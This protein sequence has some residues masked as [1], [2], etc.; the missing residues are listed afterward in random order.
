M[1]FLA[2]LFGKKKSQSPQKTEPSIKKADLESLSVEALLAVIQ[3][4]DEQL[5]LVAIQKL[6]DIDSLVKFAGFGTASVATSV[7]KAAKQRLAQLVDEDSVS[8]E[9]LQTLITDKQALMTFI[10]STKKTEWIDDL[11]NHV[12]D[13][14][15]LA[16]MAMEAAT[17][18]LRQRAAE[19]VTDK[20]LLLQIQKESKTKDKMV[21]KIV[22]DK[23]DAFKE[24]DKFLQDILESS[25]QLVQTIQQ[26]AGRSYDGQYSAKYAYLKQQWAAQTEKLNHPDFQAAYATEASQMA[27]SAASALQTMQSLLDNLSAEQAQQEA[28]RQ[29]LEK[30][31]AER[32]NLIE[33]LRTAVSNFA[34]GNGDLP[35]AAEYSLQWSQLASLKKP[36]SHES[37]SWI[38]LTEALHHFATTIDSQGHLSAHFDR[39]KQI[40]IETAD[41]FDKA[42][43]AFQS[44]VKQFQKNLNLVDK[45]TTFAVLEEATAFVAEIHK[46]RD[47]QQAEIQSL[48]RQIGGLIRKANE[49]ISAGALAKASGIRRSIDEKLQKLAQCPNHIANQLEQLDSTLLK[50]QDWKNYAVSP[51]K[52]EL[53]ASMQ[54]LVGA[55]DHPESLANKI[56]RLQD[57]WRALS[58]GTKDDDQERWDKF[59]E[60]AQQAYQP[61]R[62]FFDEQARI[63]QQ[64]LDSCKQLVAQLTDYLANYSWGV[65]NWKDV[66]KVVRVARQEWRSYSPTERAATQPVLA[67]FERILE[68]INGKLHAEYQKNNQAKRALIEAAKQ[69]AQGDDARKAAEGI[70]QLQA[71]WQTIGAALRKDEQH[72][73]SEFRDACDAVF[74]KRQQQSSEFKAELDANLQEAQT[75]VDEL[76]S[77]ATLTGEALF[78]ARKRVD[79]IRDAFSSLGQFPKAS[80]NDIKAAFTKAQNAYESAVKQAR[81]Q[82]KAQVWVNLFAINRD[83]NAAAFGV[84]QGESVDKDALLQQIESVQQWPTGGL[85]AAQQK[86]DSL[87]ASTDTA[88][89]EA[90]LRLLCVRAELLVDAETPAEDQALRREYQVSQLQQNFGKKSDA[91]QSALEQLIFEWIA[92]GGVEPSVYERLE[93]RFALARQKQLS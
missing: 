23:C 39:I 9:N 62:E 67:E 17:S 19:R 33:A 50:L 93:K 66:E 51:K 3:S 24:A 73:W 6:K 11:L 80:V 48:Q 18:R 88:A 49:S 34:I 28:E 61:C 44:R 53:I 5:R 45:E 4:D 84:A 54:S 43:S 7:Q 70:K 82:V 21:F 72:L 35:I 77:L 26:Q 10:G 74:A 25:Q 32:T 81:A 20:T 60:L 58:K 56:K 59:H 90:N 79:E 8:L 52:D 41:E 68:T 37:H 40:Q 22:K 65:P 46:Q 29:A 69:L 71:Q 36:T 47:A 1:S 91:G 85:K 64:N 76:T 87:S 15:S 92:T 55:A 16:S 2:R 31:D 38:D 13:Q 12:T 86:V 63:R 83:L 30:V 27:Q 89:N 14:A 42:F 78:D 57:E 75:L